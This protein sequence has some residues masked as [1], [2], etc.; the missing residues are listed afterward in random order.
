VRHVTYFE[1]V[2]NHYLNLVL[3]FSDHS[4]FEHERIAEFLN[5]LSMLLM[6]L[7]KVIKLLLKGFK[8]LHREL[9]GS[10]VLYG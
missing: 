7:F 4:L 10:G 1:H 5:G 6:L 8:A 9:R 2:T 3:F